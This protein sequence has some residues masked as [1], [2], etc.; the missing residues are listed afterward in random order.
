MTSGDKK[1]NL[2]CF[3]S[4]FHGRTTGAFSVTPNKNIKFHL[5]LISDVTV[6]KYNN[7]YD[8]LHG[9]NGNTAGV[10]IEPIQGE[11]GVQVADHEFLLALRE[12]CTQSSIS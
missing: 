4:G 1:T 5:L 6:L 11:G 12:R 9:V 7:L 8:M 3:Y 10:I 2:V